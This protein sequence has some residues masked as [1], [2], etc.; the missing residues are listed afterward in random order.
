MEEIPLW[1]IILSLKINCIISTLYLAKP[2][3]DS[4]HWPHSIKIIAMKALRNELGKGLDS[5]P[6]RQISAHKPQLSHLPT[7]PEALLGPKNLLLRIVGPSRAE[8][9]AVKLWSY[10]SLM[11]IDLLFKLELVKIQTSKKNLNI[12]CLAE[13][14]I[15]DTHIHCNKLIH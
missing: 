10:H 4:K 14:V 1:L 7:P 9:A 15:S 8:K 5:K 12:F 2:R 13:T 6:R 11:Q 3:K